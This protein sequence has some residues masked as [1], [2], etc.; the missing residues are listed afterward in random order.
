MEAMMN[1]MR[2]T[3]EGLIFFLALWLFVSCSTQNT[4]TTAHEDELEEDVV[5][6]EYSARA[7]Y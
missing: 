2:T 7:R 3:L 4:N 6:V 1:L 5:N